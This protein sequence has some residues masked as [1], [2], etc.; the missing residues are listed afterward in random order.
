MMKKLFYAGVLLLVAVTA[1][2]FALNAGGAARREPPKVDLDLT[3]LSDTVAYATIFSML[4]EPKNYLD[5]TVKI[6]GLFGSFQDREGN[7]YC[8]V[9][10]MD[11]TACCAA[12]L[13]CIFRSEYEYPKDYPEIGAEVTIAGKFDVRRDGKKTGYSLIDA[14]LL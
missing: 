13:D 10:L 6:R 8:S 14:D 1:A 3:K 5:K 9:T 7:V 4:T 2:F 12:G 11:P